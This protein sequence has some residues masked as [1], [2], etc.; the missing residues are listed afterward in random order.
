MEVLMC[1]DAC[2]GSAGRT[3]PWETPA[4]TARVVDQAVRRR[5]GAW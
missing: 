1:A 2:G 4:E 3:P 5:R